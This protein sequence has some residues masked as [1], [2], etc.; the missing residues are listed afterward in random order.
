MSSEN[1]DMF[2]PRQTGNENAPARLQ[3]T[4]FR[5]CAD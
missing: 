1:R 3:G 5:A 4:F 2:D